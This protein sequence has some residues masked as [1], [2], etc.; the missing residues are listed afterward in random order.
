M[1]I[2]VTQ[3]DI[4]KGIPLKAPRCAI[5]RAIRRQT[6]RYASVGT[7]TVTALGRPKAFA[8]PPVAVAFIER[9]DAG[10]LVQPFSFWL[11]IGDGA[12]PFVAPEVALESIPV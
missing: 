3:D 7:E 4:N 10:K 11:D 5:A 1:K 2:T 12:E 9:F 8:T 6:R